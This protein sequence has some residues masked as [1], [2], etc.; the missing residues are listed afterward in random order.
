Y[1]DLKRRLTEF[2]EPVEI[3]DREVKRLKQSRIPIV[4]VRWNSRRG[5]EFTWERE[6]FFKSKRGL[7]LIRFSLVFFHFSLEKKHKKAVLKEQ[8]KVLNLTFLRK[9]VDENVKPVIDDTEELKKCMEIVPDDGTEA[10]VKDIFKKEKPVDDMD[11]ILFRTLKPMFEHHVEDIIWTYQQGLAKVKNWKL[12]ESY[13]V[14]CITMQ[15]IVY[16]LLVEKVTLDN[17][18]I[19]LNAIVDG[20]VKTITEASIRR[21]LKL[22]DADGI[23]TLPTTEIFEQLAL[24]DEA[25]TKEMHDGLGRATTT[26]FGLTAEQDSGNISKTQTKATPFGPSSPRTSSEDKVTHLENELTTTKAV[27]NKALITLTQRVKKLEKKLKHKRRRSSE[28]GEAQEITKHRMKFSTASPQTDVDETLAETLLNIKRSAVKD[29]GKVIMQESE[30]PKKIKKKE[31]I[32]I[33]FDEEIAQR[34][35]EE[36]QRF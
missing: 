6:D 9:N 22:A 17:R 11:N 24:L 19:E 13:G 7:V 4:K 8:P 26:A 18:E 31:I 32:H 27:Y 20:Q 34:F 1:A 15:S 3:M 5:P 12:F 25:I 28:H 21:H 35:Y 14:Y 16:Y 30:S 2:E 10:I 29:K 36:E 23:S 33:S